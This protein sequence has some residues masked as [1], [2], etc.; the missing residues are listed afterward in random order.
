MID[1]FSRRI[2]AVYLTFNSP[3]KISCMM[4]MRE[5]VRRHG[6]LPQILVVDGGKEFASTYFETLLA[7][8]EVNKK[9]RPPAKS[10][11]GSVIERLFG[12]TNTQ[13]IHNL[14][15]NTQITKNVQQVTKSNNPKNKAV[16]T[17]PRL[18]DR[19]CEWAYIVY[20][21]TEHSTLCQTPQEVFA[22]GM[23]NSG[24]RLHRLIPYNEEFKLMTLPSTTKGTAKVDYNRGVKI[25][26]I[27]YFSDEF[28][29]PEVMGSSVA[30]RYDP[31]DVGIA[32][33]YVKGKWRKCRAY[34]YAV[35][36][37]RSEREIYLAT[38]ELKKRQGAKTVTLSQLA[39]FLKS[40]EAE[41]LLLKQRMIDR[42]QRPIRALINGD[43]LAEDNPEY[44]FNGE[45]DDSETE[46]SSN[47]VLLFPSAPEKEAESEE[48]N[49]FV[50]Y[51]TL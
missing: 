7:C 47:N 30:V 6:R 49:D 31:F 22:K 50:I 16:W 13:F 25:N 34:N 14:L 43:I 40:V 38:E 20:D 45:P 5:C 35:F 29:N 41:E 39:K 15:G 26:K 4:V 8:Y 37:N 28:R 24:E 42:E 44:I 27:F 10:R 11:F 18:F 33:A 12:T 51:Q 17:L 1:A 9:I 19:L 48:D 3:S 2:L 32:Y 46:N 23:L 36:S 21:Q